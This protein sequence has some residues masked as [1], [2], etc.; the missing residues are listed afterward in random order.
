MGSTLQGWEAARDHARSA[1]GTDNRLRRWM[2][3]G[4]PAGLLY[5]CLLGNIDLLAPLGAPKLQPSSAACF[6]T[7]HVREQSW[8]SH[9][10][11][12]YSHRFLNQLYCSALLYFAGLDFPFPEY[13]YEYA[14]SS[15]ARNRRREMH[16]LI[17]IGA[18]LRA[19]CGLLDL[20]VDLCVLWQVAF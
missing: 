8:R 2:T 6:A 4:A 18:A 9:D 15:S 17:V 1:V 5:K 13:K 7:T 19:F 14:S 20:P 10:M 16:A 11:P 12:R 3:P